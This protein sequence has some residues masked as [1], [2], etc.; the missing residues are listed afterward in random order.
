MA[1][2]LKTPML[3]EL[4]KGPWPSFVTDIKSIADKSPMAKDLLGQLELSYNENRGHWKHGGLVGVLGYGAGIIG[5]YSDVP[6]KFPNVAHF[7]TIRVNQPSGWFYTSD[8]LRKLCD[9]WDKHGSGITNMHGT[10][11][12]IIFLG[13]NT[14]SLEPCFQELTENDW[15]L[16]GSGS[17]TRTPSC[18]VGPARCNLSL[19]DTLDVCYELTHKYQDEIHRPMWPYKFKFKF[20]GCPNDCVAAAARSDLT[21]IGIWRDNIKIDQAE[22]G[23]YIDNGMDIVNEVMMMCPTKCVSLKGRTLEIDDQNCVKCMH[24]LNVMPKALRPGDDQGAAILCGAKAPIV[25]GALLS[26]V[27]VPF[28][29]IE[30]PYEELTDIIEK[31]LEFWEENG[32]NRERVGELIQRVGLGTFLEAI[33]VEPT[34]EQ[35]IEPR[36][37]PYVF[38]EE[39]FEEGDDD[40][41][42]EDE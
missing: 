23:K 39:Y 32:E 5:R 14:D 6:E 27:I 37:N 38:Y 4:D 18:C 36:D 29:K 21:V 34:P 12:D 40:D 17:A 13:T 30:P 25:K 26:S 9:I 16:G 19:Y 1:D 8:A 31:I 7:H 3:D 15:D 35:I 33:D 22:V 42:E 20:S 41:D 11:G 2:D 28:I 24:C 10:T